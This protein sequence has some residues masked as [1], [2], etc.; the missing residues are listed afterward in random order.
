MRT[1]AQI[2]K[3]QAEYYK[4]HREE[5]KARAA[6]WAKEHPVRREEILNKYARSG[7][8]KKA[9]K[10]WASKH[11]DKTRAAA[12][13]WREGNRKLANART[14]EWGRKNPEARRATAAKRRTAQTK[15]GGS[16]TASEWIALCKKY[17]NRCLA[18][19][20]KKKLTADHVIPVSKGGTSNIDNIQPLCGPCNSRKND[21]TT[22]FRKIRTQKRLKE[23]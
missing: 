16:Y 21:G 9:Q 19:G 22:D 18:C 1:K 8:A 17:G 23:K 20:K 13:K 2:K 11:K 12:K 7:K 6:K 10:L 5:A 3:Y 4:E 15:A 14:A